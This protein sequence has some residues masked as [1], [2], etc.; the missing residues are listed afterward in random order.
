[1]KRARKW[2]G[3]LQPTRPDESDSATDYTSLHRLGEEISRL[4]RQRGIDGDPFAV[5]PPIE[6]PKQQRAVIA[7]WLDIPMKFRRLPESV[8]MA[9]AIVI[10][11]EG[12]TT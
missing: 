10:S 5:V 2:G 7:F 9:K 3:R 4:G 6:T 1:M 8:T 11:S 12:D